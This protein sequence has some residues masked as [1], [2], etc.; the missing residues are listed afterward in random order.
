MHKRQMMLSP[1]SSYFQG[2]PALSCEEGARLQCGRGFKQPH[3]EEFNVW[4]PRYAMV[5]QTAAILPTPKKHQLHRGATTK[6]TRTL[7]LLRRTV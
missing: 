1:L 2:L 4:V 3:A 7:A 6:H 5:M